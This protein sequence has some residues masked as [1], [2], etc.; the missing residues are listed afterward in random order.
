M[1]IKKARCEFGQEIEI[2]LIKI[3]QSNAW[4]IDAVTKDSGLYFD[5]SYLHKVKTGEVHTPSIISS[6]CRILSLPE[7]TEKLTT[8]EWRKENQMSNTN[9]EP[10]ELLTKLLQLLSEKSK[11]A[12]AETLATL[13]N[14]MVRIYEALATPVAG[15]QEKE[16][17]HASLHLDGAT[18]YSA[19]HGTPEVTQE[20]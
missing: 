2:A 9:D 7:P 11:N 3:N 8:V 6:I 20:K 1:S 14:S 5:R 19:T 12:D 4:L 10:K 16:P 15:L 18:V 17:V 13:S